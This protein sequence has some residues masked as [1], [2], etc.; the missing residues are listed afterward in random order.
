[1]RTWGRIFPGPEDTFEPY[2]VEVTTDAEGFDDQ[3]WVTTLIQCLKLGLGESPFYGNY[4]I[5]AQ[6]SIVQQVWPDFYAYQTQQQFASRF[7]SLV[8]TKINAPEPTYNVN[9]VTQQGVKI[10]GLVPG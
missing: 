3:V 1:M 8:V 4:G 7:A 10:S 9:L 5:P 6:Q 2:W